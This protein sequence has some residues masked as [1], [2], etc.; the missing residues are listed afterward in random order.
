MTALT[1]NNM[2]FAREAAKWGASKTTE[3]P[4]ADGVSVFVG[5][6][7]GLSDDGYVGPLSTTY[8]YGFV[9]ICNTE[10]D[11]TSGSNASKYVEVI[12][13]PFISGFY[14]G[15]LKNVTYADEQMGTTVFCNT[16]N[17]SDVTLSPDGVTDTPL[18]QIGYYEGAD[19]TAPV[20]ICNYAAPTAIGGIAA[21]TL[22]TTPTVLV[23][24]DAAGS[25]E[26]RI[27]T[28]P[29]NG[30]VLMKIDPDGAKQLTLPTAALAYAHGVR[31][32]MVINTAGG[33]E[34]LTITDAAATVSVTP[35][36]NEGAILFTDGA[37][38]GG[39]VGAT[40]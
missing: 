35:T 17:I 34:I 31:M 39:I 27:P 26:I 4:L 25:G 28:P 23:V 2:T 8:R 36:Q 12:T 11:N 16:D 22:T 30:A 5:S 7:L 3:W 20:C 32:L 14:S 18:G 24:K 40:N 1:E 33:A 21:A 6:L 13:P 9:G 38:W 29:L 37:V 10:Y 15:L 19:V